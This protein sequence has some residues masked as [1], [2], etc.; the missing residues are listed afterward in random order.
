MIR[1][2]SGCAF[3]DL[4]DYLDYHSID[5][6]RRKWSDWREYA[7]HW[8][9]I[10]AK[11]K[12]FPPPFDTVPRDY[13]AYVKIFGRANGVIQWEGIRDSY[14]R[15]VVLMAAGHWPLA[16]QCAAELGHY[17]ADATS[18]LHCTKNH[19][20]DLSKDS[21]NRGIHERYEGAMISR[22]IRRLNASP[23][24]A[25]RIE[26]PLDI[27]FALVISG[28]RMV[29]EII[30]AD[31]EAQDRSGSLTFGEPYYRE[32]FSRVGKGAQE[33]LDLAAATAADLWYSAW[34]S[35]GRPPFSTGSLWMDFPALWLLP[36][37][38]L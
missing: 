29:A 8:C 38:D 5:P 22:F 3:G 21:R 17:V 9:D 30:A 7:R 23:G 2:G 16:Y 26:I 1:D 20:G 14:E 25:A 28:N 10:D 6:D 13:G 11:A 18:P 15:L 19:D 24:S 34:E 37:K 35:A 33:R 36:K 27:G 32:L 31:S 12:R 4:R